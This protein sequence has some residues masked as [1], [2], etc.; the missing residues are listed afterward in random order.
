MDVDLP[1][2]LQPD[3][4]DRMCSLRARVIR[5]LFH[6]YEPFSSRVS[7]I[8][9]MPESTP[10][11]LLNSKV[12]YPVTSLS[13]TIKTFFFSADFSVSVYSS[14]GYFLCSI[15]DNKNHLLS[16]FIILSNI[17]EACTFNNIELHFYLYGYHH[18]SPVC[19]H[20]FL[21]TSQKRQRKTCAVSLFRYSLS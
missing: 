16:V 4:I 15:S 14:T 3:C 10:T 11:T 21:V 19:H 17:T 5:S 9:T 6:L 8:P 12:N 7:K 18:I 13:D 2:R 1:F 20:C